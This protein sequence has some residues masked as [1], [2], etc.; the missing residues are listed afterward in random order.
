MT[1]DFRVFDFV[2]IYFIENPKLRPRGSTP[3]GTQLFRARVQLIAKLDVTPEMDEESELRKKLKEALLEE[4][5]AMNVDNFIVR[6]KL[7]A[8][9]KF[10]NKE[11]WEY[12]DDPKIDV[13]LRDVAGL[14]S[15]LEAD[16]LDTKLFDLLILRCSLL[17][18]RGIRG[19]LRTKGGEL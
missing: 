5:M 7:Q 6:M 4:V 16:E 18:S 15:E 3:L 13:L 10:K 9:E 19:H 1:R 2:S 17:W 11:E 14:P 12:L 8:V